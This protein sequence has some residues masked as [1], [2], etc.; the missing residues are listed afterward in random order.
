VNVSPALF[1]ITSAVHEVYIC[2]KEENLYALFIKLLSTLV[3]DQSK[4]GAVIDWKWKYLD[5]GLKVSLSYN[6]L[7]TLCRRC[8]NF[9]HS[10]E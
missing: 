2:I 5:M 9:D 3:K 1:H 10:R 8:C 6:L 7:D 4:F